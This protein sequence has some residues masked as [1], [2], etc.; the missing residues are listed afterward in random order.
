M[1]VLLFKRDLKCRTL[2]HS[3]LY[4]G[5]GTFT[6]GNDLSTSST[7]SCFQFCVRWS[8]GINSMTFPEENRIANQSR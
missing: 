1:S 3:V 7:D 4:C 6:S 8:P 5:T 2:A